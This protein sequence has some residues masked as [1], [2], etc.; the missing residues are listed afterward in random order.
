MRLYMQIDE[1][2]GRILWAP[3]LVGDHGVYVS[4]ITGRRDDAECEGSGG[5][6]VVILKKINR[7]WAMARLSHESQAFTSI[8]PQ[9]SA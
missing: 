7:R 3:I 4:Y 6:S 8:E 5:I 1:T 2:L 9:E